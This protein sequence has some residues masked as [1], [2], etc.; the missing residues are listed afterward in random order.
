MSQLSD[1]LIVIQ[2]VRDCAAVS[3]DLSIDPNPSGY[4]SKALTTYIITGVN[5]MPSNQVVKL[6]AA[7]I[8]IASET[9]TDQA[10]YSAPL[11]TAVSSVNMLKQL[12][13]SYSLERGEMTPAKAADR[14]ADQATANACVVADTILSKDNLENGLNN[15]WRIVVGKYP[16]IKPATQIVKQ[17]TPQVAS[18]IEEKAKPVVKSGI[19]SFFSVAKKVVCGVAKKAISVGKKI[20]KGVLSFF[21]F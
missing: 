8:Q 19:K 9:R 4:E 18:Y 13:S 3:S 21:G 6:I 14:L 15:A 16:A 1:K 7:A 17:Y 5:G 10:Q 12:Q 20:I 11:Q 2:T